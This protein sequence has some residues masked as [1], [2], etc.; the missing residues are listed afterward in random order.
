MKLYRVKDHQ[1]FL[2]IYEMTKFEKII[3]SS[4]TINFIENRMNNFNQVITKNAAK[5][6]VLLF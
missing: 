3:I 2:R 1:Y 6:Y 4:V 5:R